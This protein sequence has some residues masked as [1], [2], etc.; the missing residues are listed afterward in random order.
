MNRRLFVRMA[1]A[2]LVVC[3]LALFVSSA[4]AVFSG[5]PGFQHKR[6]DSNSHGCKPGQRMGAGVISHQPVLGGGSEHQ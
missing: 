3:F 5:N 2:A 6:T 1:K 4:G